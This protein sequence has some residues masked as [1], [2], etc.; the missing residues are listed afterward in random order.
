VS[1]VTLDALAEGTVGAGCLCGVSQM[2]ASL[3]IWH[4]YVSR[5]RGGAVPLVNGSLPCQRPKVTSQSST[6]CN[7]LQFSSV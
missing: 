1:G 6:H 5:V 2:G 3:K 4:T 7:I